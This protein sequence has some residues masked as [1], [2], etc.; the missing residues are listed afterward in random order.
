MI[1]AFA[2]TFASLAAAVQIAMAVPASG[3]VAS[4]SSPHCYSYGYASGR[5]AGLEAQ[6]HDESLVIP[7]SEVSVEYHMSNEMWLLIN[8]NT[9]QWV[10]EGLIRVC[11]VF[12]F[13]SGTCASNGG[14]TTY[15]QFWGD[16]DDAGN[17]YFHPIEQLTADGDNHVYE[18]WD[19][20]DGSN[21]DYDVYVDYSLVGTSTDQT[22]SSGYEMNVG[23]E[24][25]SNGPNSSEHSGTFD[26]YPEVYKN[27]T[28]VWSAPSM[29]G[30]VTDG[31]DVDPQGECFNGALYDSNQE[32]ADS[33]PS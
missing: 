5:Y 9:C 17:I 33:K 16:A 23:M 31:C 18:I 8:S 28:G 25:Y 24:L 10:E 7:A 12:P 15:E 30:S 1:A 20:S 2:L 14:G 11:S 27:S 3:Q 29:V 26:N 19:S 22:A 32:W 4:C 21:D 6:W 13:S